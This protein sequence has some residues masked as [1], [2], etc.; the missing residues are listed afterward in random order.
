MRDVLAG[1]VA[2]GLLVIAASLGTTLTIYRKRRRRQREAQE[3]LGRT[4]VAELPIADTLVLFS[5]DESAF[6]YDNDRI[7]KRDVA[8]ARVLINGVTIASIRSRRTPANPTAAAPREAPPEIED[9]P[10]GIARDRWDIV[11]ETTSEP[12]TVPCGDIR[13]RVSQEL[14]RAVYAALKRAIEH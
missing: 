12:I 3:S 8:G 1:L 13:E 14:A 11:I 2:F 9:R 10:E 4:I 6:Y 5:E 7:P